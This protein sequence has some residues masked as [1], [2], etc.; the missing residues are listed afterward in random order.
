VRAVPRLCII[1]T[2]IYLTTEDPLVKPRKNHGKT[3]SGH[4]KGVQLISAEHD[5]F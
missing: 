4:P 2:D 1:Y 3:Q 5:F